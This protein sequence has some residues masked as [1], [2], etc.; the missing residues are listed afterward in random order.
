MS[1]ELAQPS[2][3]TPA[4]ASTPVTPINSTTASQTATMASVTTAAIPIPGEQTGTPTTPPVEQPSAE[5][6][7][8]PDPATPQTPEQLQA[9]VQALQLQV[10]QA[11]EQL[12]PLN[13]RYGS[14]EA[15]QPALDLYDMMTGLK[16]ATP[17][18]ALQ[19][20][21]TIN[22]DF[23]TQ[24]AWAA[25]DDSLP[26]VVQDP[27]VRNAVIATL[28]GFEKYQQLVQ[29]G[30]EFEE[31]P[32]VSP[33]T[34]ELNDKL[35]QFEASE[36]AGLVNNAQQIAGQWKAGID[37]WFD[38]QVETSTSWGDD[39]KG[40]AADTKTLALNNINS[41]PRITPIFNAAAEMQLELNGIKF[42]RATEKFERIPPPA[43][44]R[45]TFLKSQLELKGKQ[46]QNIA[47]THLKAQVDK[48]STIVQ[49]SNLGVNAVRQQQE[50]RPAIPGESA[51]AQ[52]ETGLPA[53]WKQMTSEERVVWRNQ[54]AIRLGRISR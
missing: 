45:A 41:D 26:A 21:R 34:K 39:Y 9:T 6:T 36:Q 12:A 2:V 15:V 49:R 54:N 1:V 35:A 51:G 29:A 19:T 18:E 33:E 14:I 32:Q 43:P 53:N 37:Q 22:P 30:V 27:A 31:V 5:P 3:T 20:I 42:N 25:I 44:Q 48:Y 7:P 10:S 38:K 47:A 16:T 4:S 28:P 24:L 11:Q 40:L 46:L 50:A 13:D 17:T 8:T 52:S 23:T